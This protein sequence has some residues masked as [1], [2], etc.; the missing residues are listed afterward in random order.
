MMSG[1]KH[2]ILRADRVVQYE[3]A[4]KTDEFSLM[5]PGTAAEIDKAGDM[6]EGRGP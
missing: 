6:I 2:G 5:A 4:L 1:L 3:L